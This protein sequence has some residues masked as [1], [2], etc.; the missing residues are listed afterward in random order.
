MFHKLV[1]ELSYS[2]SLNILL[3]NF[4]LLNNYCKS[5]EQ[6]SFIESFK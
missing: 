2:I 4:K 5:K 6:I 1:K 3:I